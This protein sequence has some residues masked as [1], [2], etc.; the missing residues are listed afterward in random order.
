MLIST[1]DPSRAPAA[2]E[3]GGFLDALRRYLWVPILCAAVAGLGAALVAER[4][5]HEYTAVSLLQVNEPNIEQKITAGL[6]QPPALSGAG[7]T[8]SDLPSDLVATDVASQIRTYRTAERAVEFLQLDPFIS[9]NQVLAATSAR[10]NPATGLIEISSSAPRARDAARIA[11]AVARGYVNLSAHFDTERI[12]RVR[13]RLERLAR[14]EASGQGVPS[15]ALSIRSL[16]DAIQQLRLAAAAQPV[17]VAVVRAATRPSHPAGISPPLLG[18]MAAALGFL[19]GVALIGVREQSDRRIISLGG[20]RRALGAPVLCRLPSRRALRRRDLRGDPDP[21]EA[22]A[23]RLL[24]ARLRDDPAL[25]PA[26]RIVVVVSPENADDALEMGWDLAETAAAAGTRTLLVAGQA[27]VGGSAPVRS[28][29]RLEASRVDLGPG[30][31]LD[32]VA[33]PASNGGDLTDARGARDLLEI[34]RG[35]DGFVVVVIPPPP[36]PEGF[37]PLLSG[38]TALAVCRR[39]AIDRDTARRFREALAELD[40]RLAGVVAVGFG[41]DRY[42]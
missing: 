16:T 10:V 34:V 9:P 33:A 23:S 4:R 32:I 22:E 36:P 19:V 39:G 14:A 37:V 30:C 11:N 1:S 31:H 15:N 41:G 40:A 17:G 38:A 26:R 13:L 2:D 18:L 28:D 35:T 12:R 5:P 6:T 20:L 27:G 21:G 3:R 8:Q 24:L 42:P 7:A 29:G 25:A